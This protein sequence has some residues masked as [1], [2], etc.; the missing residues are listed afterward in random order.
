MHN[1]YEREK[2][3]VLLFVEREAKWYLHRHGNREAA[4]EHMVEDIKHQLMLVH[5]EASHVREMLRVWFDE[6]PA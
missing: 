6:L 3:R 2:Q 4:I 5:M 1:E